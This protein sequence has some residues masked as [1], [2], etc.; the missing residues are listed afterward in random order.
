MIPEGTY[1]M[2]LDFSAY[3]EDDQALEQL[4]VTKG[5]VVLNP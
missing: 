2:W 5:K 3:E 4:L 1:L